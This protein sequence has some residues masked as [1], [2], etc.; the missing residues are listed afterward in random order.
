M[1]GL[2][3]WP[4][5]VRIN[6]ARASALRSAGWLFQAR[7]AGLR[8]S[9]L[10][11]HLLPHLRPILLSQFLIYI[12]VYIVA[13]ANLG[14]LGL[15]V[16]EPLP[17]FGSMLLAMQSSS[18]LAGTHWIYLPIVLLVAVLILLESAVFPVNS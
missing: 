2:L 7:A 6:Y 15:G 17:S 1:L 8:S 10:G 4:A 16:S 12:P 3:G 9:Q 11:L 14:T 13:E 18:A 5:F